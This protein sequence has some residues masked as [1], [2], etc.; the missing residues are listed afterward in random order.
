M[1]NEMDELEKRLNE[2]F[3]LTSHNDSYYSHLDCPESIHGKHGPADAKGKC[4]WCDKKYEQAVSFSPR[5][6]KGNEISAY[7]YYYDPDFGSNYLDRY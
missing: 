3:P 6:V 4:P 7:E 1:L 5:A 2:L